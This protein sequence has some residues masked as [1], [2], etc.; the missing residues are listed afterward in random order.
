MKV[1][2]SC[3]F[4]GISCSSFLF[5]TGRCNRLWLP[6]SRCLRWIR[7]V[8]PFGKKEGAGNG[9]RIGLRC[10][11]RRPA[12]LPAISGAAGPRHSHRPFEQHRG[13]DA[14]R[15]AARLHPNLDSVFKGTLRWAEVSVVWDDLD[16]RQSQCLVLRDPGVRACAFAARQGQV[17]I[18]DKRFGACHF[19]GAPSPLAPEHAGA[20][21]LQGTA[22]S[23]PDPRRGRGGKAGKK[24][25]QPKAGVRGD[26]G[27]VAGAGGAPA[28]LPVQ[29]L[30]FGARRPDWKTAPFPPNFAASER[31]GRPRFPAREERTENI[32]S[33]KEVR[34][35][36]GGCRY[37]QALDDRIRPPQGPADSRGLCGGRLRPARTYMFGR[38]LAS[39]IERPI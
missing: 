39:E 8:M 4:S 12:G 5:S 31:P 14:D 36:P 7:E 29:R 26:M 30:P 6:F 23:I 37:S 3:P 20:F 34:S 15:T 2:K 28:G 24:V 21:T 9:C 16:D 25:I 22:G 19:F 17:L 1:G 33:E 38:G 11:L 18:R 27:S 13:A 10:D 32:P 35:R